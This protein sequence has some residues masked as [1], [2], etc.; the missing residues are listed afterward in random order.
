MIQI[1][2]GRKGCGKSK[3]LVDLANE[4]IA[5]AKGDIVFI[6]DDSRAIY[7][8]RHEIRFVNCCDYG[9]DNTD[10]LYGFISG[11]MAQDYDISSIYIDSIKN[12]FEK[13]KGEKVQEFFDNLD[14]IC[15]QNEIRV[16][17]VLSGNDDQLPEF[18]KKYII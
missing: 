12:V 1:I 9:I 17:M 2:Y 18:L 7:D 8:L 3:K 11:M 14:R 6:D 10:K 15:H 4:E 5:S 13:G 16:L